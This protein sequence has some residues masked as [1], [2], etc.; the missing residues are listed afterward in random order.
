MLNTF[1]K[2]FKNRFGVPKYIFG[3]WSNNESFTTKKIK[4][5]YAN[6]DH[7]FCD[8]YLKNKIKENEKKNGKK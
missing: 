2:Q 7:C 8:D 3:R 1:V 6:E 5:D 4:V